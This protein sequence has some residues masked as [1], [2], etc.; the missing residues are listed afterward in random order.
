MAG[1][2]SRRESGT[3]SAATTTE[4]ML[5]AAR[6][7]ALPA[8]APLPDPGMLQSLRPLQHR[9]R[10]Q[11]AHTDDSASCFGGVTIETTCA[12]VMQ[13]RWLWVRELLVH[14]LGQFRF[15]GVAGS[16]AIVSVTCEEL[17]GRTFPNTI[18]KGKG[19]QVAMG[20]GLLYVVAVSYSYGVWARVRGSWGL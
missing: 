17:A 4:E 18:R 6:L 3:T 14:D 1:R 9:P 13:H 10:S 15:K 2:S 5:H 12:S 16:H 11:S 19:E 7:R 8:V 20:R